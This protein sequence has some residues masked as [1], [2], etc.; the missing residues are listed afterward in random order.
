MAAVT[1]TR[2]SRH[3]RAPR[4]AVYRALLDPDAVA[5]WRVP[6]GMTCEVHEWDA[7]EGGTLRVS[8]SY[9]EP[10]Q[11]GKTTAHTDTYRGRFVRLV[12]GEL[13]VEADVFETGDPA[14]QGAMTSTIALADAGDGTELTAVHEGVPDGVR[15]EDNEL[16]WRMALDRLAALVER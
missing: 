4:A 10:G 14:M 6:D 15:P 8:L 7:R 12:P 16:G 9:D 5:R 11:Q 3:L 1:T 2:V 13:V